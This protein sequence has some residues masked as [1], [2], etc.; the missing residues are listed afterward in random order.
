M[1]KI[2]KQIPCVLKVIV[3]IVAIIIAILF[4]WY[5]LKNNEDF[6]KAPFTTLLTIL[7]AVFIS[8]KL[9]QY[10][11]DKRKQK[12]I[13]VD[14]LLSIQGIILKNEV[15]IITETTSKEEI[16]MNKRHISNL[17]M[18]LKTYKEKFS[19]S[20]EVNFIIARFTEYETFVGDH[21]EDIPYLQKS[22]KELRR[23]LDLMEQKIFSIMLKLY[24]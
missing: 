15:V 20:D 7:V 16:N 17:L 5:N 6:F 14:I 23:P 19:I 12:D 1:K 10:Q 3:A 8:Y 24:E 4:I 18:I 9:T 13:I 2:D 21:I 11:T 22:S